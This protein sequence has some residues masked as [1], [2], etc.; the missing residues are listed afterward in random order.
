MDSDYPSADDGGM[1]TPPKQNTPKGNE[2][3][4]EGET[5][6]IPSSLFGGK[7]PEPGETCTFKVVH[8]YEDEC[9]VEYVKSDAP[10]PEGEGEM[11]PTEKRMMPFA[12]QGE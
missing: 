2:E 11:H 4:M 8:C 3:T 6:L 1:D 5:T 12:N 10:Q 9:E 7:T